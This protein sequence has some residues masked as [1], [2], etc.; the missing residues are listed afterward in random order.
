L[1]LGADCYSDLLRELAEYLGVG[2]TYAKVA[3]CF[4]RLL[5]L[6]LSTQAISAMVAEDATDVEAFYAQLPPP[7]PDDEAAILVIQADGK[8]VP[9]V[10]ETPAAAKVRL[11]KGDKPT[12]KKEAASP[13]CAPLHPTGAH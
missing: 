2:S 11:G 12:R 1:A 6:E 3:D 10:R 8:G 9:M 4:A 7:P 13:E 5:G